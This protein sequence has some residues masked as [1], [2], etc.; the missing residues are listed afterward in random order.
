MSPAK[1]STPLNI[2][3]IGLGMVADTQVN[4]IASLQGRVH[5]KGVFA[6]GQQA[7][8]EYAG[9]AESLC[10]YSPEVYPSIEA[11]A[12]D[13]ELDFVIIATPP[14]ARVELVRLFA[15]AKCPILMEKP[16]ERTTHTAQE[17]VE[18]CE[19][20]G[21]PL[22]MVFQHR[23]RA[24]SIKLQ[25]LIQSGALG[26]LGMADISA[27]LWRDQSYYDEPGRGTYERDGGGV[28]L[29]QAIHTLD[30]MLSLTGDVTEVQAMSRTTR[31]HTMESEDFVTAGL[32]F[33]NGAVGTLLASTAS[34]PGGEEC[35][36]LHFD[37]A[38]AK[39]GR[40]SLDVYW[41]DGRHEVFG[42]TESAAGKAQA[43]ANPMAFTSSWHAGVIADF[44]DA[45][46]QQRPPMIT[47][48]EALKVHRLIE[49]LVASSDQKRAVFVKSG[50]ANKK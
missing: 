29:S 21:V 35:I 42:E 28:L 22:G 9:K 26:K 11:V 39:L 48:R 17:I 38:V 16:I 32:T 25:G 33:K 13:T 45:I 4:A 50:V 18:L 1:K 10:G 15:A 36:T 12:D 14:N 23:A 49:A 43:G 41:R 6:R 37:H 40:D 19:A 24:A 27:P 7:A 2:A 46:T 34:Y 44:A 5:L 3:L 30:L 31:F 47:G 8:R 20:N